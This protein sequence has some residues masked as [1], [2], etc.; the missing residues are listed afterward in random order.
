M[1]GFVSDFLEKKSLVGGDFGG[2]EGVFENV[3]YLVH[4]HL[5]SNLALSI[6][7]I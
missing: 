7:S 2:A 1:N 6:Q 4:Q 3:F 5:F